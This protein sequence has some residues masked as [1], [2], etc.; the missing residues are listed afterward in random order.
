MG[1]SMNLRFTI[2]GLLV[3][4]I[5]TVWRPALAQQ[6]GQAVSTND[7]FKACSLSEKEKKSTADVIESTYCLA[8]IRGFV[9]SHSQ[10][11]DLVKLSSGRDAPRFFCP[12]NASTA[13]LVTAFLKYQKE[14]P[15]SAEF[16]S[17]ALSLVPAYMKAFPCKK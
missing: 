14:Q 9:D 12:G 7:L 4:T 10:I 15:P 8:Y 6:S 16:L 17:T 2:L 11:I 13:Q 1:C 5:S 3:L